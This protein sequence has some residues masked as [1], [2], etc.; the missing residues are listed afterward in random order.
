[1]SAD[2]CSCLSHHIDEPRERNRKEV[3]CPLALFA[4]NVGL[5]HFKVLRLHA[6][7]REARDDRHKPV[8]KHA[9]SMLARLV[10]SLI[11]ELHDLD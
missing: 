7:A 5:N 11:E 3:N 9:L 1:M 2:V 8:I 4:L 6:P 10:A